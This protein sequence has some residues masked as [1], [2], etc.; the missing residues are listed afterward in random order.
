MIYGYT[1]AEA[2]IEARIC[3][4]L[5][6][7]F[8]PLTPWHELAMLLPIFEIDRTICHSTLDGRQSL[9]HLFPT[10]INHLTG[11]G[12]ESHSVVGAHEA[13]FFHPRRIHDQIFMSTD[14]HKSVE[15]TLYFDNDVKNSPVAYAAWF[16][17]IKRGDGCNMNVLSHRPFPP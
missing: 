14:R 10:V 5:P 17:F 2:M 15:F 8:Q 16:H 1:T 12:I 3:I 6:F 9:G 11:Y 4:V 7:H 13:A